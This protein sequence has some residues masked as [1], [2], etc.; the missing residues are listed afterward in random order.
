M[1]KA[2]D[3]YA[4]REVKALNLSYFHYLQILARSRFM[5]EKAHSFRVFP[6]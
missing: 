6:L 1:A 5:Y 4:L 3:V 2:L